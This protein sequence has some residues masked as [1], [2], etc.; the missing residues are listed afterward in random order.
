MSAVSRFNAVHTVTPRTWAPS[1]LATTEQV[2]SL[3]DGDDLDPVTR[4]SLELRLETQERLDTGSD[5]FRGVAMAPASW[6]VPL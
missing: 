4:E 6:D 1:Q 5:P 3:L 2:R